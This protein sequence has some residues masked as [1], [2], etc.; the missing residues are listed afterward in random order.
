M[1][2]FRFNMT[3][4]PQTIGPMVDEDHFMIKFV[5]DL[6][7]GTTDASYHLPA[8]TSFWSRWGPVEDRV[9]GRRQRT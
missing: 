3:P 4:R 9:F 2:S 1:R 7:G 5:P 8:F 6:P